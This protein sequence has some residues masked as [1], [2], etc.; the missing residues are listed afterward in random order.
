[1][2]PVD[3]ITPGEHVLASDTS[4]RACIPTPDTCHPPNVNSP[5]RHNDE[6]RMARRGTDNSCGARADIGTLDEL[7]IE[8]RWVFSSALDPEEVATY[9]SLCWS[10]TQ[11]SR[12]SAGLRKL[13]SRGKNSFHATNPALA[14]SLVWKSWGR[15]DARNLSSR[16]QGPGH[17]G[18]GCVRHA[19]CLLFV[20]FLAK[21]KGFQP[22]PGAYR[23]RFN[24]GV[25]RQS[26]HGTG[27][28]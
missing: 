23:C 27:T 6:D 25:R 10:T 12:G 14:I 7:R 8:F 26:S 11:R 16:G 28:A 22:S 13:S 18:E 4:L 3:N 19:L 5:A 15:G 20:V 21:V 17:L 2:R 24:P 1:M 9:C